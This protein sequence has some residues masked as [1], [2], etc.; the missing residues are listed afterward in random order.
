MTDLLNLIALHLVY[1][2]LCLFI[3]VACICRVNVMTASRNRFSW[4][5]MYTLMAAF[6]GGELLDVL[7]LQRWMAWY[8]LAGL[9]AVGLNLWLTHRHW[10]NGPPPITC[11]PGCG[12]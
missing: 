5:A 4:S 9:V 12:P 7:T 10:S 8:E 3:I 2:V 1:L 11:K 6:A